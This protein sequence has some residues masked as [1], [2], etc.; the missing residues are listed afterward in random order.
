LIN[1]IRRE[2]S[3]RTPLQA[4]WRHL[5]RVERWP[6][7]AHHIARVELLPPGDLNLNTSGV[8]HLRNGIKSTFRMTELNPQVNWKWTGPF[9]RM[10]IHYDHRSCEISPGETRISSS[11]MPKALE[12]PF[13]VASSPLSIEGISNGRSRTSSAKW[14]APNG[15]PALSAHGMHSSQ[16]AELCIRVHCGALL[17]VRASRSVGEGNPPPKTKGFEAVDRRGKVICV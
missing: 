4:A 2:F 5:E 7:W 10:T 14:R 3:V 15:H 17:W 1:L 9:L 11:S 16:H 13:S 6:T 12:C 8:I